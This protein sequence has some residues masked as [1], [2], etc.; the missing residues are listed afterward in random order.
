M[1]IGYS[2]S[3]LQFKFNDFGTAGAPARVTIG[4]LTGNIITAGGITVGGG[5]A[6]NK[7]TVSSSAP[8]TLTDGELY[9]QY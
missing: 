9:L 2:Q 1:S 3:D 8:G 7:I 4:R 6:L 5:K